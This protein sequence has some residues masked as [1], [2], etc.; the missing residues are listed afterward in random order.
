MKRRLKAGSLALAALVSACAAPAPREVPR[1]ES[2]SYYDTIA[3][4]TS[5]QVQY[6]PASL[7]AGEQG[8]CRVRVSFVRDGAITGA[9][10][11]ESSGFAALDQECVAAARRV[12]TFPPVPA[13]FAPGSET[14][15]LEL[16]VKFESSR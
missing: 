8:R 12:G 4:A 15:T 2:G 1:T 7:L 6:P 5:E 14:F 16:P 3:R 13:S 10:L 9:Q 11:T